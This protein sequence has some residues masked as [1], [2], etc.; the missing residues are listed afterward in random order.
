MNAARA[1]AGATTKKDEME[2]RLARLIPAYEAQKQSHQQLLHLG[3]QAVRRVSRDRL[4]EV[5]SFQSPPVVIV[6]ALAV[7]YLL[8]NPDAVATEVGWKEIQGMLQSKEF[9][10]DILKFRAQ[11]LIHNTRL[12]TVLQKTYLGKPAAGAPSLSGLAGGVPLPDLPELFAGA[13]MPA[14]PKP[15][16]KK[17][18]RRHSAP[19]AGKLPRLA[20]DM[21]PPRSA[22]TTPPPMQFECLDLSPPFGYLRLVNV[23]RASQAVGCL[24]RWVMLKLKAAYLSAEHAPIRLECETLQARLR[25]VEVEVADAKIAAQH[26]ETADLRALELE[27]FQYRK[28]LE[29]E[30]A[31]WFHDLQKQA[32]ERD[33]K[34]AALRAFSQRNVRGRLAVIAQLNIPVAT[35]SSPAKVMGRPR[36]LAFAELTRTP[37]ALEAE[38]VVSGRLNLSQ[39]CTSL[40]SAREA[41]PARPGT[42][43]RLAPI[44]GLSMRTPSA[45]AL[46]RADC[47]PRCQS[48]SP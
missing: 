10:T 42:A 36:E 4:K 33:Q 16:K 11:H 37:S 13:D 24:F 8:L 40:P 5:Q 25:Y 35:A 48:A 47:A 43:P 26:E 28:Q 2:E 38:C 29:V 20:R 3:E 27:E 15:K 41:Y 39:S 19:K 23:A 6:R 17:A 12:L 14:V 18:P 31:A 21:T 32:K 46:Q 44:E 45:M 34:L 9:I 22:P 30:Q 7:V 1:L